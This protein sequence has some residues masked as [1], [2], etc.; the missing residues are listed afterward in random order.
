MDLSN[1][2]DTIREDDVFD[3]VNLSADISIHH[4]AQDTASHQVNLFQNRTCNEM[5]NHYNRVVIGCFKDVFQSSN[6]NNQA[7]ILQALKE[8]NFV[9]AN[10]AKS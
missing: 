7:E 3:L 5:L 10:R 2:A 8:L 6:T 9:L 1:N 4:D